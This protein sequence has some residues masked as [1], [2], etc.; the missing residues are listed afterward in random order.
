MPDLAV[1]EGHP[2]PRLAGVDGAGT[3]TNLQLEKSA[4]IAGETDRLGSVYPSTRLNALGFG[5]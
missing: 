3:K 2:L 1:E 4:G 5:S